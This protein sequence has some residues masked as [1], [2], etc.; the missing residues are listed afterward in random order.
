M[1]IALLFE[2]FK[3]T[4]TNPN[5]FFL[6]FQIF[7]WYSN[8]DLNKQD[9]PS[10]LVDIKGKFCRQKRIKLINELIKNFLNMQ[11]TEENNTKNVYHRH[12]QF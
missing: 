6:S 7:N 3:S 1:K 2:K 8:M 5:C 10:I 9:D 11:Y 12:L 4:G